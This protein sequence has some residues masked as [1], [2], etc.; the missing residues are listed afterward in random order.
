MER[1]LDAL[2]GLP[3]ALLHPLLGLGAALENILPVIPADTFVVLGGFVSALGPANPASVFLAV[4]LFNVAGAAGVYL[5]GRRY[6]RAF[7]RST[8]GQRLVPPDRLERMERFYARWGVLAIFAARFLPGFRAL[9]PVFAGV[10]ALAPVRVIPPL[11]VASAIWYGALVR[12]GY[13]AGDNLDRVMDALTRTN[14]GLLILSLLLVLGL[15]ALWWRQERRGRSDRSL[16]E[17]QEET[18][19]TAGEHPGAG[20]GQ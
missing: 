11:A 14:R 8:G 4:W 1:A 20:E 16:P 17:G 7:F 13:L 5:L 19:A 18:L 10:S 6:G 9:V 2:S 15:A 3:P 12:V